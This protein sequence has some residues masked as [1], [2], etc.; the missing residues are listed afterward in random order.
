MHFK[1]LGLLLSLV[2][3]FGLTACQTAGKKDGANGGESSGSSTSSGSGSSE[4]TGV[5]SIKQTGEI[6]FVSTP[7]ARGNT[8][9]VLAGNS[10]TISVDA[11]GAT[12]IEVNG[13][14]SYATFDNADSSA[15]FGWATTEPDVGLHRVNF[16]ADNG[17]S[18]DINIEVMRAK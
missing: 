1:Q 10:V 18:L 17:G 14:S 12:S 15:V 3:V 6:S 8:I 9:S 4:S 13:A 16:S 5:S 11:P 2:L 7:P